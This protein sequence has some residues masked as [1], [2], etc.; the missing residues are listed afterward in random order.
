M[1]AEPGIFEYASVPQTPLKPVHRCRYQGKRT[2]AQCYALSTTERPDIHNCEKGMVSFHKRAAGKQHRYTD[3]TLVWV[4]Q[5]SRR[6]WIQ[7]Q[8]NT[9]RAEIVVLF[10]LACSKRIEEKQRIAQNTASIV[11]DRVASADQVVTKL[12]E[13]NGVEVASM[14]VKYEG[15]CRRQQPRR[16][17]LT[18]TSPES[19]SLSHK[20]YFHYLCLN[21]LMHALASADLTVKPQKCTLLMH[22]VQFVK[23]ALREGQCFLSIA[24]FRR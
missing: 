24:K 3:C 8:E 22:Q 9:D 23:H 20:L 17:G 4:Q 1:S 13:Q 14:E 16:R 18:I 2:G 11:R 5:A 12:A 6:C 19:P 7:F 15:R 21:E 10:K